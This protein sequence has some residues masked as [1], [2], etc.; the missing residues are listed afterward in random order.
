MWVWPALLETA[1]LSAGYLKHCPQQAPRGIRCK[2]MC[3]LCHAGGGKD[4][5]HMK[6]NKQ[7]LKNQN[8]E[9]QGQ[10]IR[11]RGKNNWETFYKSQIHHKT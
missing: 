5:H 4:K 9:I 2:L 10:Q 6:N 8:Y 3:T 11:K 1:L 7:I